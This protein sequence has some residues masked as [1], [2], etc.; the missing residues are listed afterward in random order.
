VPEVAMTT[1]SDEQALQKIRPQRRQ[2]CRRRRKLNSM[3]LPGSLP[4]LQR[5]F[6]QAAAASSG[7]QFSDE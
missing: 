1:R 4:L 2:W 7:S 6:I 3:G 5:G